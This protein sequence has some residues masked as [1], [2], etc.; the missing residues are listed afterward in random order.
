MLMARFYAR[1]G[2]PIESEMT[3][4]KKVTKTTALQVFVRVEGAA[5]RANLIGR[6]RTA[7]GNP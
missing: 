7:P 2:F 5:C 1:S 6:T 3:D 4:D